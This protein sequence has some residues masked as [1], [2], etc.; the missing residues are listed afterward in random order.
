MGI[1]DY[2]IRKI[3]KVS[4]GRSYC[5][6]CGKHVL[7]VSTETTAAGDYKD[8]DLNLNYCPK[9]KIFFEHND[10]YFIHTDTE[11]IEKLNIEIR[12]YG[13]I[14][15]GFREPLYFD[16]INERNSFIR[17]LEGSLTYSTFSKKVKP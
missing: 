13:L 7:Y 1:S 14:I 17:K 4:E 11:G 15:R 3:K 16:S 12:K 5:P 2:H 10:S 9:C 8:F 6:D